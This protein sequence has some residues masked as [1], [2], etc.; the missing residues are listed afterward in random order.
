ML[1]L[2]DGHS[3]NFS[4]ELVSLALEKI[5]PIFVFPPNATHLVQPINV[6]F[7]AV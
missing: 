6:N 2:V 3:S 7:F 4:S 5:V 1:L